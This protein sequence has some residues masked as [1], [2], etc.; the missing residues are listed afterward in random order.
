MAT[1]LVD[2]ENVH[3]EGLKG[4][5]NLTENDR[6]YLFYSP[7]A[8]SITFETHFKLM[9]SKAPIEMF[10][11][12]RTGKNAIDF[13]LSSFLGYLLAKDENETYFVVSKD[14]GYQYSFDF[15]RAYFKDTKIKLFYAYSI[16]RGINLQRKNEL[17]IEIQDETINEEPTNEPRAVDSPVAEIPTEEPQVVEE[18][19]AEDSETVLT[20]ND[21][22]REQGHLP[23]VEEDVNNERR[24][25]LR[26]KLDED[27]TDD[28]LN[29][30]ISYLDNCETLQD[31]YRSIIRAFGQSRGLVVYRAVKKR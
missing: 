26:K 21:I 11:A 8:D 29:K 14:N 24:E 30:L 28:E 25:L 22:L 2:F 19:P 10:E 13:H 16:D 31:L 27:M 23:P 1:Y 7:N 15:W 17:S 20:V 5:D 4:V 18:I 12:K 3:S 9:R 6:V